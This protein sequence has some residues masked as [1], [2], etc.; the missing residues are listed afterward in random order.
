MLVV[1]GKQYYGVGNGGYIG[2]GLS[3]PLYLGGVPDYS[4]IPPNSGFVTGFVGKSTQSTVDELTV[5]EIGCRSNRLDF[6]LVCN[7]HVSLHI[8]GIFDY[9][10]MY[11]YLG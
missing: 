3:T 9:I 11:V 5:N 7:F 1:D 4:R 8:S 6:I 10:L 2:L